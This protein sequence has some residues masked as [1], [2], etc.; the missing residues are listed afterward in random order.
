MS[1]SDKDAAWLEGAWLVCVDCGA[2]L[3]R[4]KTTLV[5]E[6]TRIVHCECSACGRKHKISETRPPN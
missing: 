4:K 2:R 5:S 6:L 3:K 1:S